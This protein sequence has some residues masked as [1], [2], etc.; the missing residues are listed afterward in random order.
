MDYLA[1]RRLQL[2]ERDYVA[3]AAEYPEWYQASLKVE[4]AVENAEQSWRDTPEYKRLALLRSRR[5]EGDIQGYNEEND[6]ILQTLKNDYRRK[7]Y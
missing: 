4:Q 6:R 5:A 2:P 3:L 7:K 1:A